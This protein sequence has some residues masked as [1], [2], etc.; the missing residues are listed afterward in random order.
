MIPPVK[1][2]ELRLEVPPQRAAAV[3]QE[4]AGR[5]GLTERL[6][7]VYFDT[8]D[9]ALAAA[10]LA[11]R[12]RREGRRWVQ[13]LKGTGDDRLT[14]LEHEVPR[15]ATA[16]MPALEPS[17]HAGT[18]AGDR[19]DGVLRDGSH[20]DLVQTFRTDVRRTHRQ[21]RVR[22]GLLELAFDEGRIVAGD[23][24]LPVCEL[25]IELLRGTPELVLAAARRWIAR[26]GLWID[27]RSKAERGDALARGIRQPA[28]RKAQPVVL[29]R[30]MSGAEARRAVL[31]SCLDQI[32][33][34]AG[35]VAGGDFADEHVHQ[36]RVGLRR[37]RAACRFFERIEGGPDLQAIDEAAGALFGALG[38]ARDIAAVGRPLQQ[39][40]REALTAVG[41]SLEP[42]SLPAH[43]VPDDPTSLV[44][45]RAAQELLL[46]LLAAVQN[47][48]PMAGA[49][50]AWDLPGDEGVDDPPLRQHVAQ[51][52]NRWHRQVE[53]DAERFG[54]LDDEA[55]HRLRKRAKR[56][57]YAAEFF[58]D[59]WGAKPVA[60][61][62]APLRELQERLGALNDVNVALAAFRADPAAAGDPSI[63][64][65]L[66]W[67]AARRDVLIAEAKPAL[68]RF[69][70]AKRFWK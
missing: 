70:D 54:D 52:L 17:L 32:V 14:R 61:Y 27:V 49:A 25:E 65:A 8:A 4:V 35:V 15:G 16:A 30:R 62:L 3:R 1:E 7:A 60:R 43:D 37:L 31:L 55:R 64:F 39:S 46:D 50:G 56:L 41:L 44:R 9:R 63:V 28:E 20:G 6:Q 53:R 69:G 66:G 34:N 2:I 22:G 45:A 57:R 40:L 24:E 5:A 47:G 33:V 59:L 23:A 21:V 38:A 67:L 13:T 58:G 48:P 29:R 19:L 68:K 26:H 51:G 42:A 10:G 18:P 11:L 36:L 12:L